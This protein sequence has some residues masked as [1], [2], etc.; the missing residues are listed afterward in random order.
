MEKTIVKEQKTPIYYGP[1]Y[2]EVGDA[3]LVKSNNFSY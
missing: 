1:I 3:R 2:M